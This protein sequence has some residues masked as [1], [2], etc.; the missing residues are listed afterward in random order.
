M[1]IIKYILNVISILLLVLTASVWMT[2]GLIVWIIFDAED[3]RKIFD[4]KHCNNY[5]WWEQ[6]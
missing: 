2:L 1:G 5:W 4:W 6:S 3:I